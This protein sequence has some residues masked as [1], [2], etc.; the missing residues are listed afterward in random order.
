MW[1]FKNEEN[2]IIP[3]INAQIKGSKVAS[4]PFR[5]WVARVGTSSYLASDQW[6]KWS[7]VIINKYR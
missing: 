5:I 6:N 4:Y 3:A 1:T 7:V 2:R